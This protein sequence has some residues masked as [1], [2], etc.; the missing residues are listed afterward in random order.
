LLN[1]A[2]FSAKLFGEARGEDSG[3]RRGDLWGE[4]ELEMPLTS[5]DMVRS[6]MIYVQDESDSGVMPRLS[7]GLLGSI[8]VM[9]STALRLRA[10]N[11]LYKQR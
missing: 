6:F 9:L 1:R 8:S 3:D 2:R 10:L 7:Y 5:W 11:N 4:D